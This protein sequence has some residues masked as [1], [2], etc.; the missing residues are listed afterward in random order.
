VSSAEAQHQQPAQVQGM[1]ET[2]EWNDKIVKVNILSRTKA[3]SGA[4]HFSFS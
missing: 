3:I 4:P 2:V 1:E